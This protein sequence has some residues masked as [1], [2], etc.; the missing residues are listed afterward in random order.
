[1]VGSPESCHENNGSVV[2][3]SDYGALGAKHDVV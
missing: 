2:L 3:L 1:M